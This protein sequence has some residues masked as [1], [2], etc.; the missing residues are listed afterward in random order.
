[1]SLLVW[2]HEANQA[3]DWAMVRVL[4]QTIANISADDLLHDCVHGENFTDT[5]LE[6]ALV[7]SRGLEVAA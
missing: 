5:R 4:E 6:I 7:E 2:L 3:Q 1:M